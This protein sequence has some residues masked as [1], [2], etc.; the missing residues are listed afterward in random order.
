MSVDEEIE[1]SSS[2]SGW[3]GELGQSHPDREEDRLTPVNQVPVIERVNA[4]EDQIPVIEAGMSRALASTVAKPSSMIGQGTL[5]AR[6]AALE[7]AVQL[8]LETQDSLMIAKKTH[9]RKCCTIM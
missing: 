9:P 4:L 7:N 2:V 5:L 8:L 1:M 6:I 3:S